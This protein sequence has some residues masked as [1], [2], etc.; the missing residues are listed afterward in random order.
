VQICAFPFPRSQYRRLS[1]TTKHSPQERV[2]AT[3]NRKP[4]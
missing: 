3:S 1:G 2:P 4:R